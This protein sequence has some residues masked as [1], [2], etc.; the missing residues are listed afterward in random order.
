LF[1]RCFLGITAA[2]GIFLAAGSGL[3]ILTAQNSGAPGAGAIELSPYF[4]AFLAFISGF[5]AD[6]AFARLAA[7]GRKLFEIKE[8]SPKV[9]DEKTGNAVPDQTGAGQPAKSASSG[10]VAGEAQQPH[11]KP[12]EQ[13]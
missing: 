10:G 11:A 9:N 2:L 6:D 3:L 13:P 8:D 4:V 5:M 1:R 7:G 12:N